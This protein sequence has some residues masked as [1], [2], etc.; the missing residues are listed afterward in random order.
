[1]IKLSFFS[2]LALD[3]LLRS[4]CIDMPSGSQKEAALS[5]NKNPNLIGVE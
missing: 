3:S 1:M 2:I 4:T 5:L